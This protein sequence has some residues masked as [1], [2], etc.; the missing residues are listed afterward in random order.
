MNSQL[1]AHLET[2]DSCG[3]NSEQTNDCPSSPGSL[4][5]VKDDDA[6]ISANSELCN[7]NS[8]TDKERGIPHLVER[9]I[10]YFAVMVA[11]LIS[12]SCNEE[13]IAFLSIVTISFGWLVCWQQQHS[14]RIIPRP[15]RQ[16]HYHQLVNAS[17]QQ[18][19]RGYLIR[20][21]VQ[22]DSSHKNLKQ[23]IYDCRNE[24]SRLL[25][26]IGAPPIGGRDTLYDQKCGL[27]REHYG[28]TLLFEESGPTTTT[29][30]LENSI[31]DATASVVS[32]LEAHVQV[33]LT[34]DKALYWLKISSSL[35]W[36]LGPHSQCVER[37]ER[38]AM[39]KVLFRARRRSVERQGT[40]TKNAN[41]EN[42]NLATQTLTPALSMQ[43]KVVKMDQ[44]QS[45]IDSSSI[46][47]LSSARRNIAHVIVKEVNS[48]VNTLRIFDQGIAR[49]WLYNGHGNPI[50]DFQGA[51][52]CEHDDSR[53]ENQ[54]SHTNIGQ[55]EGCHEGHV[56]I[57]FL[58]MPDI[59]DI[60]WI[61]ASRKYLANLLAYCIENFTTWDSLRILSSSVEDKHESSPLL[62]SPPLQA[63]HESMWSARNVQEYL[64]SHLLLDDEKSPRRLGSVH[65]IS[66]SHGVEGDHKFIMP[67]LQYQKQLDALDAAL[68][69]FQQYIYSQD[70]DSVASHLFGTIGVQ[71]SQEKENC[72]HRNVED[73][74]MGFRSSAAKLTWW[75]Q[76]KEISA[77][78][79]MLEKEIGIKFFS[80]SKDDRTQNMEGKHED[81]DGYSVPLGG[82]RNTKN[83]TQSY[84]HIEGY[85]SPNN[86][87][88]KKTSLKTTKTLVFSGEGSKAKR[89]AKKIKS[90]AS[91]DDDS[92]IQSKGHSTAVPLPIVRDTFSEHLLVRE[93]E[94]RI[95]SVAA[96]RE[97]EQV[98]FSRV[99]FQATRG[100]DK[101]QSSQNLR[102]NVVENRV[103]AV[104][105]MFPK[106]SARNETNE[107]AGRKTAV[108]TNTFLGASGSLLEELKR[109]IRGP[110]ESSLVVEDSNEIVGGDN[111]N[112]FVVDGTADDTLVLL[113]DSL[114]DE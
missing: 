37:V 86:E 77:A 39:S 50:G 29:V 84:E 28:D 56:K 40:R 97:E 83:G 81:I 106:N 79:Q 99:E 60:A 32:F 100:K 9:S 68:W 113:L 76:V 4:C 108:S 36:G 8:N 98:D 13:L 10:V 30:D 111:N 101:D 14:G 78:C 17:G 70:I 16:K 27:W 66:C 44:P 23:E 93:L 35:H 89:T 5:K 69:S 105:A 96:L 34:I 52:D 42:N 41:E 49:Q 87:L 109:N 26:L 3:D 48:V 12:S 58:D 25:G 33:V 102:T 91:V 114:V 54:C 75:N 7:S 103:D 1:Y 110:D 11:F 63:L 18:I 45:R 74:T 2:F 15:L 80:F 72:H 19:D 65:P 104:N 82:E 53:I 57:E 47:A 22:P 51:N 21:S 31:A 92:K 88:S 95:R 67:L 20:S 90:N 55:H 6:K 62:L 112:N 94:N 61:K 43:G 73:Q 107:V 59:I 85:K 64:T 46:L 24:S 38:A 71:D